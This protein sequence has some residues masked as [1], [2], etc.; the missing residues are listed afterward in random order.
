MATDH[1]PA[2]WST[3]A[4]FLHWAVALL[5]LAQIPLGWAAAR[6]PLSPTKLDLFVWHKSVG[7]VVLALMAARIAWQA[8]DRRPAW[9]AD[10]PSWERTA[11]RAVHGLLYAV[12]FALPLTGW[13][14]NSAANVP[15]SVFWLVPLPA[16]VA[17]DKALAD[18][19][20]RVHLGLSVILVGLLLIHVGA[21]LRHHYVARDDVLLRMLTGR[22][23]PP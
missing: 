22:R 4:R 20:S 15:F 21:A 9:P 1:P 11:A 19:V 16:L 8:V 7:V 2:H 3:P 13:I 14:V 18:A 5:V 6:W 23:L 12:L 10:M 17:P